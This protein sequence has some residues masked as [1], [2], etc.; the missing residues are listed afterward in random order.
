[1]PVRGSTRKQVWVFVMFVGADDSL[2][3]GNEKLSRN[4]SFLT[5]G[6]EGFWDTTLTGKD[7]ENNTSCRLVA[8]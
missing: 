7:R 3:F 4:C 6:F 2:N 1:M 5:D 8:L